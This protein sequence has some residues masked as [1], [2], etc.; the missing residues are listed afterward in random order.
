LKD[1][2]NCDIFSFL[3]TRQ[4]EDSFSILSKNNVRD[5]P[6]AQP[7]RLFYLEN[8]LSE[9]GEDASCVARYTSKIVAHIDL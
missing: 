5:H 9:I 7:E 3:N 8:A 4:S 6:L 2:W 1:R